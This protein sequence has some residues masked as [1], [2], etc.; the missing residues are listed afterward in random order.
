MLV[1]ISLGGAFLFRK[2]SIFQT[3]GFYFLLA[4]E[5]Q[6]QSVEVFLNPVSVLG[7]GMRMRRCHVW[8]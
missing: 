4:L 2:A 7:R 3:W 8:M 5:E 6:F 1:F